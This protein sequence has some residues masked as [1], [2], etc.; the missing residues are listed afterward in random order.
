MARYRSK[1]LRTQPCIQGHRGVGLRS[2]STIAADG[3]ARRRARRMR[4]STSARVIGIFT[5]PQQRIVERTREALAADHTC[6][7]SFAAWQYSSGDRHSSRRLRPRARLWYHGHQGQ[8]GYALHA[9][10]V[11]RCDP[12]RQAAA[13]PPRTRTRI[14]ALC[15][16]AR[17]VERDDIEQ[18]IFCIL[19][20]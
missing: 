4:S 3:F 7:H 14:I 9:H 18:P 6:R 13:S 17:P 8:Q 12:R 1:T 2:R 16:E 15:D 10:R 5:A 11:R 20:H 19:H